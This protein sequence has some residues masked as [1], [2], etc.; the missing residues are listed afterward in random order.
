MNKLLGIVAFA[1]LALAP[2]ITIAQ[3]DAN[4][5]HH[6]YD[7]MIGSWNCTNATPSTMGGPA[8]QALTVTRSSAYDTLVMHFT[9]KNFD[10]YG[11]LT[12]ETGARTWW[13][14]WAYPGGNM[15]NEASTA[16]AGKK[17]TVWH[18]SFFNAS[19]G[20]HS[21]VRDTLTIASPTKFTDVSEDDSSGSMKPNYNGTCEKS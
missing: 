15:S 20:T 10:Q 12:Y 9:G 6:A 16:E 1:T 3:S 7:W 18:G 13:I 4:A 5:A 19:N 17:T 14:S 2:G 21:H 11:F 8:S